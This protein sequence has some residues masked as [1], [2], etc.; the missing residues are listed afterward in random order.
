ML[1]TYP[2]KLQPLAYSYDALE[3]YVD[4]KTMEIHHDKHLATYLNNLNHALEGHPEFHHWPLERLLYH[5]DLLPLAIQKAVK[6]NGGGVY[7]HNL[8]FQQ[9]SPISHPPTSGPLFSVLSSTFGSVE[10]FQK[11]MKRIGLEVFGSGWTLL[12]AEPSGALGILTLANQDTQIPLNLTPILILD[13]WEHAYY[14]KHQN[15]RAE[16]IDQWWQVI[17]WQQAELNYA[18]RRFL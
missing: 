8:F 3:P 14:L 17:N 12:V 5:I 1:E 15:R 6:H 7:N 18:N 2:F 9:L 4:K 10:N 16:Y 11:E 13:L